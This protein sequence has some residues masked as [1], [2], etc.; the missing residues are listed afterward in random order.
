M[1]IEG[2]VIFKAGTP[3]DSLAAITLTADAPK[4]VCRAGLKLEAALEH[5]DLPVT[6]LRYGCK[7]SLPWFVSM[8]IG[9]TRLSFVD[10]SSNFISGLNKELV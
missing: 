8:G 9:G 4:F 1:S 2:K 6:G 7:L 5:F 10:R 3:V